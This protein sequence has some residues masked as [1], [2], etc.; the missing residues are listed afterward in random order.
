MTSNVWAN[1]N[2]SEILFGNQPLMV[3]TKNIETMETKLKQLFSARDEVV[4]KLEHFS[5]T[6]QEAIYQL[7]K[8]G[9]KNTSFSKQIDDAEKI[10]AAV[11]RLCK[12]AYTVSPDKQLGCEMYKLTHQ[13]CFGM[14]TISLNSNCWEQIVINNWKPGLKQVE[15]YYY[16]PPI[17]G[18]NEPKIIIPYDAK[19]V[20]VIIKQIQSYYDEFKAE[21]YNC[22]ISCVSDS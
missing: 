16:K 3:D 18:E 6:I 1:G 19:D 22:Y 15:I 7:N 21:G 11:S 9:E 10:L 2:A 13:L 8:I 12:D 4:K 5:S 17:C 14:L 20:S